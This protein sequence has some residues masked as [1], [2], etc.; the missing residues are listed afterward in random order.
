MN[1]IYI[2]AL[3]FLATITA[4]A[5]NNI[6]VHDDQTRKDEEIGIP[7]AMTLDIDTL[8]RQWN[9]SQYL[10]ADTNCNMRTLTR[11]SPTAFTLTACQEFPQ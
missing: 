11:F 5:Q 4:K 8:L 10:E 7:E 2:I 3:M 9:A 1:K 6:T